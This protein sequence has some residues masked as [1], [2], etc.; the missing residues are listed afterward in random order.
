M[1]IIG[2]AS[3]PSE[4]KNVKFHSTEATFL[5]KFKLVPIIDEED[6][7]KLN[8]NAQKLVYKGTQVISSLSFD[9]ESS[10]NE[11]LQSKVT[12]QVNSH[13]ETVIFKIINHY[14]K[15]NELKI[16]EECAGVVVP[17]L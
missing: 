9:P 8:P 4:N 17:M 6:L 16:V 7:L 12:D 2:F 3:W 13:I 10:L 15:L 1:D 14:Q 11:Q 5:I